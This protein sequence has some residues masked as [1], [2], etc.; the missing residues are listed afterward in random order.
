M[1][2]VLQEVVNKLRDVD[3]GDAKKLVSKKLAEH[4]AAD[5]FLEHPDRQVTALVASCLAEM[6]RIFV[7]TEDDEMGSQGIPAQLGPLSNVQLL[8][9]LVFFS[10]LID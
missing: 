8:E 4:F 1:L 9:V 7:G 2:C 10:R 6:F 3:S 5:G